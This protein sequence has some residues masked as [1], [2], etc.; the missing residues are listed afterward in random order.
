M[1]SSGQNESN[2]KDVLILGKIPTQRSDD[3]ML[4]AKAQYSIIFSR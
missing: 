1:S 4:A 2:K 3:N